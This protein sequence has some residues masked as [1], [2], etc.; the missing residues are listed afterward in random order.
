MLVVT[1]LDLLRIVDQIGRKVLGSSRSASCGPTP[2]ARPVLQRTNEGRA[3]A[4]G[5]RL[6]RCVSS[7]PF[8]EEAW[9]KKFDWD[10]NLLPP[11][12]ERSRWRRS[13]AADGDGSAAGRE[14]A[15]G[16]F[17]AGDADRFIDCH[18]AVVGRVEHEDLAFREGQASADWH[19]LAMED[20]SMLRFCGRTAFMSW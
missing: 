10:R 2:R 20:Y 9:S 3:S 5:T 16:R 6:V 4:E 1:K 17:F 14:N 7:A 11:I 8:V 12:L 18:R 19:A 13:R 15:G